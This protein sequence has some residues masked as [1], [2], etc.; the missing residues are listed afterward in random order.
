MS[1]GFKQTSYYQPVHRRT[2]V[3]E[4][5]Y[6][7]LEPALAKARAI[8]FLETAQVLMRSEF[9]TELLKPIQLY[10]VAATDYGCKDAP[11]LLANSYVATQEA[12]PDDAV[13]AAI[14]LLQ[15]AFIRGHID[16]GL[17]LASAMAKLGVDESWDQALAPAFMTMSAT[18]REVLAIQQLEQAIDLGSDVAMEYLVVALAYGGGYIRRDGSRFVTLCE[19]LIAKGHQAVMLGFGAW[20]CGMTVSGTALPSNAA[21]PMI[22]YLRGF[23]YLLQASRGQSTDLGLQSLS[24]ICMAMV[25]G[26]FDE[27]VRQG[28]TQLLK[29]EMREDN[30]LFA[31]YLGWYSVPLHGRKKTPALFVDHPLTALASM[32]EPNE[33]QA[34]ALLE[35]V[36]FSKQTKC[37]NLVN[38]ISI[39]EQMLNTLF[40]R[41]IWRAG[42]LT[43]VV[44]ALQLSKV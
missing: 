23:S 28:L 43:D 22:D 18:D 20:L 36:V 35:R 41:K 30:P 27:R 42:R 5:V 1:D 32:V 13:T 12:V 6:A 15:L 19:Q 39:A 33:Q 40:G 4:K 8:D 24:L 34:I 2:E 10:L 38:L 44:A 29:Q 25:Q 7:V 37:A 11:F 9:A 31:L 16:A 26:Q 17:V 14:E 3:G 21:Q